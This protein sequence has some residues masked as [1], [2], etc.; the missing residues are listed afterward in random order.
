VKEIDK[1]RERDGERKRE[2]EKERKRE[3]EK[4]RKR[5]REKE[6]KRW[7][8]NYCDGHMSMKKSIFKTKCVDVLLM[9]RCALIKR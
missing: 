1:E 5:E 3:R 2:R 4:E 9:Q 7:R 8:I 6:R